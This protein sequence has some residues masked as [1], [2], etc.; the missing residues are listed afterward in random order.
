MKP[1]IGLTSYYVEAAEMGRNHI[2]GS[3]DQDY[4][5]TSV[6]YANSVER[7][8]G[9]PVVLPSTENHEAICDYVQRLDGLLLTGGEDIYPSYYGQPIK[10]GLGWCAPKRDRFE[11]LLLE[12][13]I[14]QD[15]PILGICRGMQLINVFY[16]GT[17]FQDLN[18]MDFTTIEHSCSNIP[19]YVGCHDV[20][21]YVNTHL[22]N[23]LQKGRL[24]VNSKHH[25]S[26]D[27]LGEGLVISAKSLDGVIEGI[28][29]P[30]KN[31]L[32]A[33]QWHPEMMSEKEVIQRTIFDGFVKKCRKR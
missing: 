17:L 9:L 21:I 1:L 27:A 25:Q 4:L 22:Y 12:E 11:W 3:Y 28:E 18:Q 16:G 6:D 14:K 29:D 15:K 20:E 31:F 5:M 23:M 8:G 26:V 33:V 24:V 10:R 19:R 32:V 7:A 30:T 2:R 13:A